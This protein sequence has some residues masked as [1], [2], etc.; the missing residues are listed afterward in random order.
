MG[1]IKA[2]G[3][4]FDDTLIISEI[5]KVKI[6]EEIFYK[7]YGIKEGVKEAYAGLLGKAS[8]EDKIKIIIKKFLKRE[9]TDKE[10]KDLNYAFDKGYEYK[11]SSCPLV[12]CTNVLKELKEQVDFMFLLSLENVNVVKSVAEFC[13]VAQYFDEILGGPTPKLENF[14]H[15]C[16]KHGV[17]PE[18]TIYIG[19]SKGDVVKSKKLNFKF[20]G[21]QKDFSYRKLLEDL[22][23]DFTFSKLCDVPFKSIIK[24]A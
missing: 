18:D 4:D 7:K 9:A 8:R 2:I 13:G 16:D 5:E 10:V 11:L 23:A 6:F 1:K 22:G 14:K 19:D 3:F 20:I 17:N 21:I 15:V 24:G 12:Q